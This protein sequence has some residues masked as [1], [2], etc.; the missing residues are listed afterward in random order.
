MKFLL[1]ILKLL[2]GVVVD[3]LVE[4]FAFKKKSYVTEKK[5]YVSGPTIPL[6]SENE[7][8]IEDDSITG[9]LLDDDI[10]V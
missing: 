10:I 5:S 7:P 6:P 9:D 8:I 4:S 3:K 1:S 2:F